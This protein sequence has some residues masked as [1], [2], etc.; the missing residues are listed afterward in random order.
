MECY[1]ALIVPNFAFI[2]QKIVALWP[3]PYVKCN[4]S[5]QTLIIEESGQ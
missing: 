1:L 2:E 4:A 3:I 5:K